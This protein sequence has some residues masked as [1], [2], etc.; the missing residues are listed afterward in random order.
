MK[1]DSAEAE[2]AQKEKESQSDKAEGSDPKSQSIRADD[3]SVPSTITSTVCTTEV[4]T[5][6]CGDAICTSAEDVMPKD[7]F[8]SQ[9]NMSCGNK[10]GSNET[11]A[12]VTS[13]TVSSKSEKALNYIEVDI[14]SEKQVAPRGRKTQ[15]S[16][17]KRGDED[18]KYSTVLVEGDAPPII[19]KTGRGT[20]DGTWEEEP[21]RGR[22]NYYDL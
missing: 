15:L 2:K 6:K 4:E 13:A 14:V 9:D 19:T 11:P 10:A 3:A 17:R 22:R 5:I 18:V 12:T 8:G 21:E 7:S 1:A 16:T 20:L